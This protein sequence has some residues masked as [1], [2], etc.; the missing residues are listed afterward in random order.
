MADAFSPSMCCPITGEVMDDPVMDKEGNS[1]EREAITRWLETS[2]TSPVTRTPLSVGDLV[3]NRSLKSSI[4]ERKAQVGGGS[5]TGA[6]AA[7][8]AG[9]GAAAAASATQEPAVVHDAPADLNFQSTATGEEVTVMLQVVPPSG[10]SRVPMDVCCVID[11][12]GSMCSAAKAPDMG[13]NP[14]AVA[15]DDGLSLLDVVKH[16]VSTLTMSL[17]PDDR[18]SIVSYSS[19]AVTHCELLSLTASGQARIKAVSALLK[20]EG[21][22]N[23]WEG[24][25]HGL[26]TLK[27]GTDSRAGRAAVLMLLTDGV[28][29]VEPPRGSVEMLKRYLTKNSDLHVSVNTFGFGYELDSDMLNKLAY[30]GN[31]TYAFIPDP[32]FVGTV[33][34]HAFAN[35]AVMMA[36]SVTLEIKEAEGCKF[37]EESIAGLDPEVAATGET[38]IEL[39]MLQYEQPK[40]VLF[41]MIVPAGTQAETMCTVKLQWTNVR[42]G[43]VKT[44]TTEVKGIHHGPGIAVAEKR[45]GLVDL[46]WDVIDSASAK[47]LDQATAQVRQYLLDFEGTPTAKNKKSPLYALL[48]DAKGQILTAVSKQEYY[49][50]WGQHF[51]PSLANSHS[52]QICNNFKDPG[53]QVYGGPMFQ[54]LR[55]MADDIFCALPPP[56]PS[57]RRVPVQQFQAR[58]SAAASPRPA[59]IDMSRYHNRSA[60]CFDGD[61]LVTMALGAAAA[62]TKRVRDIRRGDKVMTAGGGAATVLCVVKTECPSGV[63]EMVQLPGG[64]KI[65]PYHPVRL[66]AAAAAADG[67]GGGGG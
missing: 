46:I 29:N 30:H 39:P 37:V 60:G 41:K 14:D 40:D 42:D 35:A 31:G 48:Q 26:E 8:A 17:G 53:V 2:L 47:K 59:A 57:R 38:I 62:D 50:K 22:T 11:T 32:G 25:R 66:Q 4:E 28:P 52:L 12:S 5:T 13:D 63:A 20:P 51:L 21:R 1:Y 54:E 55:D 16:A 18:M 43:S 7:T 10:P 64:L 36:R 23:L 6:A 44:A 49:D 24:V 9:G 61:C 33:F 27:R 19:T 15:E 45:T 67:G 65:T 56:T 34:V 58:A 3:P